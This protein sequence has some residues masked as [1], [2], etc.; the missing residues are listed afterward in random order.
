MEGLFPSQKNWII[1]LKKVNKTAVI[2]L[3]SRRCFSPASKKSKTHQKI[4][5][6]NTKMSNEKVR[7]LFKTTYKN[8][9]KVSIGEGQNKPHM[10]LDN[11]ISKACVHSLYAEPAQRYAETT[12]KWSFRFRERCIAR[13]PA[14]K[15]G[16]APDPATTHARHN[17]TSIE[18]PAR[19]AGGWNSHGDGAA[20]RAGFYKI[21]DKCRISCR[22]S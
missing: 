13:I 20:V 5:E 4:F 1:F 7:G 12:P 19:K 21:V 10:N 8:P 2:A 11:W 22:K 16:V 9:E 18:R 3:I 6:K 17:D 15:I 14:V